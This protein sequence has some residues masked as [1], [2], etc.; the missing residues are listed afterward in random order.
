MFHAVTHS[1]TL[2]PIN[3]TTFFKT[4][5]QNIYSRSNPERAFC[6]AMKNTLVL[7]Q[8]F[9]DHHELTHDEVKRIAV[10]CFRVE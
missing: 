9:L 5:S 8:I 6:S 3:I 1:C 7:V 2:D 4:T 10:Q